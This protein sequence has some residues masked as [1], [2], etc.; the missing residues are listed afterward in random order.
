[1]IGRAAARR[2]GDMRHAPPMPAL[3]ALLLAACTGAANVV[4]DA[5]LRQAET[6]IERAYLRCIAE[7]PF[8]R[9]ARCREIRAQLADGWGL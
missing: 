4:P 9:T 1:L 7:D 5:P 2:I 6:E 3:A 8:F